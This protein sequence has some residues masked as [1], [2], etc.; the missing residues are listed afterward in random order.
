[1][2]R[3]CAANSVVVKQDPQVKYCQ[4][5]KIQLTGKR[6]R[7]MKDNKVLVVRIEL[8]KDKQVLN[9]PC[10]HH[11]DVFFIFTFPCL[12]EGLLHDLKFRRVTQAFV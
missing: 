4:I 1:M 7:T 10:M 2:F 11:T 6:M 8:M 5:H 3:S 12:G 9:L